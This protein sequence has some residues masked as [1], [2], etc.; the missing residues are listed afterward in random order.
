MER[1]APCREEIK[2]KEKR[3]KKKE[4]TRDRRTPRDSSLFSLSL[5][6]LYPISG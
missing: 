5:S 2:R 1:C 6:F 4:K 3:E